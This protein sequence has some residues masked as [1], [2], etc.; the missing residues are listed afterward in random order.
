MKRRIATPLLLVLAACYEDDPTRSDDIATA[1]IRAYVQLDGDG[2]ST[3]LAIDVNG[4]GGPV[5]F[6]GGD[7]LLAGVRGSALRAIPRVGDT[8]EQTFPVGID[9]IAVEL[10]RS[11]PYVNASF[12]VEALPRAALVAPQTASRSEP[13]RIEWQPGPGTY[14]STISVEGDCFQAIQRSSPV[15]P[16]FFTVQPTDWTEAFGACPV[17]VTLTRSQSK[18]VP[19]NGWSRV[20]ARL[21]QTMSVTLEVTP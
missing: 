9:A 21:T 20:D 13:L 6:V 18:E 4:P 19:A 16:G 3:R 12:E 15:D 2:T 8:H 14:T 5:D 7:V 17:T 10:R 11:D 1:D